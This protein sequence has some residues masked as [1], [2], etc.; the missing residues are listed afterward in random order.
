M[1]GSGPALTL[2]VLGVRV[3]GT[4]R[5]VPTPCSASDH[6]PSSGEVLASCGLQAPGPLSSDVPTGD[7]GCAGP[8]L[9]A[10]VHPGDR[11]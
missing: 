5:P 2:P 7:V 9:E 1:A 6:L 10:L 8:S 11:K 4:L 3:E